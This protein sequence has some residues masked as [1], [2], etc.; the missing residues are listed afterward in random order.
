MRMVD[1]DHFKQ[2]QA[3]QS[4]KPHHHL[5]ASVPALQCVCVRVR[6][7][8]GNMGKWVCTEGADCP[9]YQKEQS[10]PPPT[11]AQRSSK[12]VRPSDCE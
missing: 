11:P 4:L 1:L 2:L 9:C 10:R 5:V 3:P 8:A 12:K 7:L 6:V